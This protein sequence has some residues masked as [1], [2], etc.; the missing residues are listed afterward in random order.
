M[1]NSGKENVTF[2]KIKN[3]KFCFLNLKEKLV[4][5]FISAIKWNTEDSGNGCGEG[6]LK[7]SQFTNIHLNL[8]QSA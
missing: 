2:P 1:T 8:L 7:T 6:Y 5:F 4:N 3:V